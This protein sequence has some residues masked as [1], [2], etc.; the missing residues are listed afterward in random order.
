MLQF[1]VKFVH[2][3]LETI[4][5]ERYCSGNNACGKRIEARQL[6]ATKGSAAD[7]LAESD[8][9][10]GVA[11]KRPTLRWGNERRRVSPKNK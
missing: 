4:A 1:E 9:A 7:P 2:F 8:C 10:G 11:A 6:R 3:F 5:R